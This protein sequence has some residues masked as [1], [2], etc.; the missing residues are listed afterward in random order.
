M[1]CLREFP[2]SEEPNPILE[3]LASTNLKKRKE[4][5]YVEIR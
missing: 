4:N 2:T 5:K 3:D 1:I